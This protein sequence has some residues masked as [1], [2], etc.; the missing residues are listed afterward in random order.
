MATRKRLPFGD[1]KDFQLLV[2][3]VIDYAIYMLDLDG[4]V[5]SWNSGAERLK[6]YSPEEIIGQFS[7]AFTHQKTYKLA[8]RRRRCGWRGKLDALKRKAGVCVRTAAVFGHLS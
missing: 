3:A 4:H 5:V 7:R 1:G 6:G 2:N 8:Y